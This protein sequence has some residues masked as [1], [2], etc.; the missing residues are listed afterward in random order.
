MEYQNLTPGARYSTPAGTFK[1]DRRGRGKASGT[2]SFVVIWEI[3]LWGD[4]ILLG[5]IAVP[6]NVDVVRLNPDGSS[7]PVLSGSFVPPE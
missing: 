4:T 6:Y 1:T 7:T 3:S 2:V 5:D